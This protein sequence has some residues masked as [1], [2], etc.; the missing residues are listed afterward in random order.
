M[1][2]VLIWLYLIFVV[3]SRSR[4][5]ALLSGRPLLTFKLYFQKCY[6]LETPSGTLFP[7]GFY[8]MIMTYF[9]HAWWNPFHNTTHKKGLFSNAILLV[10]SCFGI[11]TEF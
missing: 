11:G 3:L 4:R 10:I 6:H 8:R 5:G 9:L 1:F 2:P 7:M